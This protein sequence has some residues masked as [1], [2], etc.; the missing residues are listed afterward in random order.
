MRR[1]L[2]SALKLLVISC[3]L[4]AF[5]GCAEDLDGK[6]GEADGL[7]RKGKLEAA[8]AAYDGILAEKERPPEERERIYLRRARLL[9]SYGKME[10]GYEDIR[11][12]KD[13]NPKSIEPHLLRA[14]FL[15]GEK[16]YKEVPEAYAEAMKIAPED[17]RPYA[18]RGVFYLDRKNDPEAAIADLDRALAIDSDNDDWL[19]IRGWAHSDLGDYEKSLA[20]YSRA[21][22]KNPAAV[23]PLANRCLT[24][25]RAG[26]FDKALTDCN[27]I[28]ARYRRD[29]VTGYAYNHRGALHMIWGDAESALADFNRALEI[30]PRDPYALANRGYLRYDT[31][32]YEK[33]L[34]DLIEAMK[35]HSHHDYAPFYIFLSRARLKRDGKKDLEEFSKKR[36]KKKD[37]WRRNIADYLL[38]G[39]DEA[40]FLKRAGET[41][42]KFNRDERA[43]E[44]NFYI[45]ETKDL[46]GDRE[47]AL[48]A[49]RRVLAFRLPHFI[50]HRSARAAMKRLEKGAPPKENTKKA[51]AAFPQ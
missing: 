11:R 33:A 47:A 43:C 26:D 42:R 2:V 36:F 37:D 16:R 40:E 14:R 50:E 48:A 13:A 9:R 4:S 21:L 34:E 1:H 20:D 51:P 24:Y 17:P 12:A 41:K 15:E 7:A 39:L 45:A 31:G 28:I 19:N 27:R 22:E 46:A 35:R 8:V 18:E 30:N 5:C 23:W 25:M 3:F 44:A 38:G 32:R 29:T 10:R 49:Y 6:L